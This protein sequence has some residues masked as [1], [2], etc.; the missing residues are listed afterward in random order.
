MKQVLDF[1]GGT[2]Y[3]LTKG[4]ETYY[5]AL[6]F[7][8]RSVTLKELSSASLN[9][10]LNVNGASSTGGTLVLESRGVA[11]FKTKGTINKTPEV[12]L[13]ELDIIQG[14]ISGEPP[15]TG[16]ALL[17]TPGSGKSSY[18]VPLTPVDEFEGFQQHMADNIAFE[19]GDVF[20]LYDC[21]NSTAWIEDN[22]NPYSTEGWESSA[23]GIRCTVS[24]VYDIYVKFKWEADE[25]YVGPFDA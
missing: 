2:V 12:E 24:G 18:Y 15:L 19:A 7:S 13:G 20:V 4:S 17:V 22:L 14:E 21:D 3:S 1:T 11:V 6:N 10:S 9:I 23:D 5:V 16:F 25:V 8:E